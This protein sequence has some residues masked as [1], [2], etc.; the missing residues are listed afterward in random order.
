MTEDIF[1]LGGITRRAAASHGSHLTRP[2]GH[3]QP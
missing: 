1:G 3:G 2:P